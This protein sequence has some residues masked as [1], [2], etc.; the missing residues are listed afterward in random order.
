MKT[1]RTKTTTKTDKRENAGI[2][3]IIPKPTDRKRHTKQT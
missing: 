1:N 3:E 2:E